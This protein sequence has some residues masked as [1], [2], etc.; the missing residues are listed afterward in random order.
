MIIQCMAKIGR[1][2]AITSLN[3]TTMLFYHLQS[4]YLKMKRN[5]RIYCTDLPDPLKQEYDAVMKA[6]STL[7][8]NVL[9]YEE[10]TPEDILTIPELKVGAIVYIELWGKPVEASI[11]KVYCN[12][13]KVPGQIGYGVSR[14][15]TTV[16]MTERG[17]QQR[18]EEAQKLLQHATT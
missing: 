1:S 10:R 5:Q 15:G 9:A 2:L 11:T 17:L 6:L 16:K 8:A 18:M 14:N 3:N 7:Q 4:L 12:Y 13:L